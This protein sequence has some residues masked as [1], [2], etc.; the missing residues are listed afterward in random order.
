MRTSL[1]IVLAAGEGTRMRSALPKVLHP[2]GGLPLIGHVLRALAAAGID[3][4]AAVIGPDHRAVAEVVARQSPGATVHVQ[5]ERRGTAHAVLAARDAL[6]EAADDV[7]VVF[8]DTPFVSP[9]TVRLI[10]DT[11]AGGASVVVGG[12][13]PANPTGYGR[14]IIEG[15]RLVAIREEKDASEAERAITFVNGGIMGLGG[16][17]ALAILQAIGSD[18]AQH[19]FYLTDAVAIANGRGLAVQAVQVSADEVFGVNDRAQL[20]EAER[21][22]Q[23]R[24]RREVMANGA[25]LVA[26]DTV[27]LSH[28]T[29][30]GRDV[31][32]EPNV[33]FGPGVTVDDGV[34]IRGFSHL[35]GARIASGAIVGPFARLRPGAVIGENAHIGNFVEIKQADVEQGAKINHLT[36]IGDARVGAKSNIGAGTITGNY[37][38]VHKH[39]TDIGRG[40]FIGSNSVLVAPVAIGDGAY[41]ASGS[42][43]TENVEPDALAI[44]R[45]RQVQKPDWAAKRPKKA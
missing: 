18:N 36:Y 38:G 31:M 43:I 37:D 33:V 17:T 7:I 10:R 27:F 35:E 19:E 8:G 3:R 41:V 13:V 6:A 4:V 14:L 21:L 11:L 2:V 25:T 12:M 24:R 1:A 34:T 39:H 30:I 16:A 32:L 28:D 26:P 23:G 5:S 42:V 22:F 44:A 45:G 40:A 29:Q 20:A 9:A 15:N